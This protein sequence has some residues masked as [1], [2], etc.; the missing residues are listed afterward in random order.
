[1]RNGPTPPPADPGARRSRR[2]LLTGGPVAR[3][4]ARGDLWLYRTI[5]AAARP[6][7]VV[8]AVSRFSKCGEHAGVW[9]VIGGVGTLVDG[10][11]RPR[12]AHATKA[13]AGAYLANF[14]LKNVFRRK[15]P[16]LDDLPQL[17]RTP[18]ALSFPS[19]HATSSFAAARAYSALLPPVPLYVLAGSMAL[20]RV[21]LGVHYPTDIVAGATFG[22]LMGG[23]GRCR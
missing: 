9:L 10:P 16:L 17:I 14:A 1:M 7:E 13:V 12:W 15:R 19:A 6:P 18:T 3:S 23:V 8:Q 22:T 4:I 5:R 20:S 2:A 11:R 21:Y